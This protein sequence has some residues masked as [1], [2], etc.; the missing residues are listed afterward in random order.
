MRSAAPI[1]PALRRPETP[2]IRLALRPDEAAVAL[3]ICTR[4]LR[5][6]DDGPAFVSGGRARLYPISVLQTWLD[7][8]ATAGRLVAIDAI[9]RHDRVEVF[10]TARIETD[11][12]HCLATVRCP[13]SALRGWN[14]FRHAA[15]AA[16]LVLDPAC[17]PA[18]WPQTVF[19]AARRGESGVPQ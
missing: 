7:E 9:F 16:D 11:H 15:F 5:D 19:D 14:T 13:V 8:R 2:A 1:P 4:T 6:L 18:D 3:G 10:V 12:G 17:R